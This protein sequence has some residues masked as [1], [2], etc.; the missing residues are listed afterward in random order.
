MADKVL[1]EYILQDKNLLE[2]AELLRKK[3]K[4]RLKDICIERNGNRYIPLKL[5]DK[6]NYVIHVDFTTDRFGYLTDYHCDGGE[7]CTEHFCVHC[8]LAYQ[9][10]TEECHID[11]LCSAE[12]MP[13]TAEVPFEE[14][15]TQSRTEAELFEERKTETDFW[16]KTEDD[17]LKTQEDNNCFWE[18]ENE[19]ISESEK[20]HRQMQ[21][22]LGTDMNTGVP[23]Y[24]LPNNTEM[25][26]NNNVGI[27]GTMGTGKT[28]FTKSLIAQLHSKQEDNYD[29]TPTG[30][31]IFDYK[32]DYNKSKA[33]FVSVTEANVMR[34]YRVKYNPFA[35]HKRKQDIPLMPLHIANTFTDTISRIY[36]LGSKQTSVL[37]ENII[38]AYRQQGIF[39][40]DERTW[41][42]PAPTFE[43]VYRQYEMNGMGNVRDSLS[44]VMSK[45]HNF[46]IFEPDPLKTVSLTALLKGTVVI[47]LSG[48]D[49]DIQSLII[50]ITLDQFYSQMQA[51]GS[52][53]TDGKYRQLKTFIF[54]DEA[55]N[56]M[57]MGFPSLRKILKEGREFGAG[58]ILSTQSLQHFCSN[59]DNYAKYMNTWVI[60]NVSDLNRKDVEFVLKQQQKSEE[61]ES[62]YMA[63]KGLKKHQSIVRIAN[64]KPILIQD[65]PFWQLYNEMLGR[66]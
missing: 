3:Y 48:Y 52:S 36:N 46:V 64:D 47:D 16:T 30:I 11:V 42:R 21:I 51:G 2:E 62:L 49:E 31:L 13:E 19:G 9:Y 1:Y 10:I 20:E 17:F 37:L 18:K 33:D 5:T 60:H 24:L 35:L 26:L 53:K 14:V 25:V 28:Q 29:G 58:V 50:A 34:P 38:E 39:P 61:L 6:F 66:I 56:F 40:E 8:L 65:K 27:I 55:D 59:N 44:A 63:I 23:V 54:V 22:L 41:N 12:K 45:L 57:K 15:M 43:Q 4:I 7:Q 32:G